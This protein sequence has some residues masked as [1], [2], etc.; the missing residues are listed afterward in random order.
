MDLNEKL[1]N[2]D[3]YLSFS[4]ERRIAS[5][6]TTL[7]WDSIHGFYYRDNETNKN[8][9]LD[10]AAEKRWVR[11]ISKTQVNSSVLLLSEVK[12]MSG[13]HLLVSKKNEQRQLLIEHHLWSGDPAGKYLGVVNAVD[14]F[15]LSSD[16]QKKLVDS[17]NQHAYPNGYMRRAISSVQ[18]RPP[19]IQL[20]NAFRETSIGSD[21]NLENS[22]FWRSSEALR[23]AFR[24]IERQWI[25]DFLESVHLHVE[26]SRRYSKKWLDDAIKWIKLEL[27]RVKVVHPVVFTDAHIWCVDSD[28]SAPAQ[29]PYARFALQKTH[30]EIDWWCD[31]VNI[32]YKEDYLE[33]ISQ[34]Y[35]AVMFKS[36]P[37]GFEPAQV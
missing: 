17:L 29:I 22:V 35:E 15:N 30:H 27:N 7:G 2:S 25:M 28:S 36:V 31:V 13:F 3:S 10:V 18:V 24:S 12:T 23:S 32:A 4:A 11:T 26:G 8:R 14:E 6:M 20:F 37:L 9:E 34:H 16:E 1:R 33:L 5:L 19:R 21:K